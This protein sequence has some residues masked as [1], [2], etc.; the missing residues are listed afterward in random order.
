MSCNFSECHDLPCTR[1]SSLSTFC[2]PPL[3]FLAFFLIGC[4]AL[5]LTPKKP[6]ERDPFRAF[7]KKYRRRA[8][9]YEEMRELRRAL[10]CWQIVRNFKPDDNEASERID[11]LRVKT[12]V[13]A[14]KHFLKGSQYLH[15]NEPQAALREFLLALTYNPDHKQALDSIRKEVTK[16]DFQMYEIREGDT[17]RKIA[18]EVYGDPKKDFLVAYF[19]ALD[20]HTRLTAGLILKLPSIEVP[21]TDQPVY[22][23]DMLN[24]AKSLF[25]ARQYQE[26]VTIAREILAYDPTNSDAANLLNASNYHLGRRF[27]REK[28]YVDALRLFESIDSN[29][30]NV[31]EIVELLTKNLHYQAELHYKTGMTYFLADELNRAIEE[32]QETLRLNPAH[33]MARRDLEKAQRLLEKLRTLD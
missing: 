7:P 11:T 26:A 30:R 32:W 10:T 19:N 21:L 25:K 28:R 23:E 16:E 13:E 1:K 12:Q 8:L 17:V 18:E 15:D 3:L 31:K 24:M 22:T 20:T 27:I 5:G 6:V 33:A 4:A 9:K 2:H 14:D 29:Y